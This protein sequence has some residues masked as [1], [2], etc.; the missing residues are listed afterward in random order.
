LWGLFVLLALFSTLIP[1]ALF[2][3]GLRRLPATQTGILATAEPVI[4]VVSAAL[5][6]NE[7]LGFLQNIGA[8][9]VLAASAMTSAGPPREDRMGGRE[10]PSTRDDEARLR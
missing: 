10:E 6:L 8:V 5:F 1:F 2:Y 7:S 9:L 4:A 3:A